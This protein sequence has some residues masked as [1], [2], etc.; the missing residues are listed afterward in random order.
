MRPCN[1]CTA[2]CRVDLCKLTPEEHQLACMACKPINDKWY[3][4]IELLL[5]KDATK[6]AQLLEKFGLVF[7][8]LRHPPWFML[9]TEKKPVIQRHKGD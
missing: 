8:E 3:T 9:T 1:Q 4:V 6:V 2:Q 5:A 7:H